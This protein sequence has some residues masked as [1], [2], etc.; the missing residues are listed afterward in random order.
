MLGYII[1]FYKYATFPH[2]LKGDMADYLNQNIKQ[3]K[4]EE[5]TANSLLV[6]GDFDR[7]NIKRVTDFT[8]Y[9]DVDFYARRWLGQR[10]SILLYQLEEKRESDLLE[11]IFGLGERKG[12][13]KYRNFVVLTMVTL[14][15]M[16]HK[17]ENY[18]KMLEQCKALIAKQLG[19]IRD[20]SLTEPEELEYQIYGSFSSSELVIIWSVNQ[21]S[22]AL[23]LTDMLRNVKFTYGK[24]GG[25][26]LLPFISFYSIVAQTRC[27]EGALD[28]PI[29]G[30]AEL[31][32]TFQDGVLNES[33]RNRFLEDLKEKLSTVSGINIDQIKTN[34]NAGEYDYSIAL[35]ADCLCDP[36]KKVFYRGGLLHWDNSLIKEYISLTHVQ[37]YYNMNCEKDA[38]FSGESLYCDMLKESG[39]FMAENKNI[40]ENIQLI[41]KMIYGPDSDTT[42]LWNDKESALENYR[43]F[44]LRCMI[45]HYFP[46]TDGLCDTID[47]LYSDYINNCSNL[48]SSAWASDLTT[49]F[50]EMVDYIAD[51]I[52]RTFTS[53]SLGRI[54]SSV[55]FDDIKKISSIFIQMIYH[56]AQSRRTVFI[57]PSCHLRYMGQYDMILHA[58]YGIEKFFINLAYRLETNDLQPFLVPTFM[59]DV[60]PE[61]STDM[62]K[63][64]HHYNTEKK[65]SGIFSINMPLG[66]MTDFLR[67]SMVMCHETAHFI[68][69]YDR[70]KRNQVMGMLIFSEFVTKCAMRQI[71]LA[72]DESM[73]DD[74]HIALSYVYDRLLRNMMP[75]VYNNMRDFYVECVHKTVMS[76]ENLSDEHFP[77]WLDYRKAVTEQIGR[78]LRSQ[79][80]KKISDFLYENKSDFEQTANDSLEELASSWDGLGKNIFSKGFIDKVLG[81]LDAAIG[82]SD[83]S[84]RKE[85][86]MK[87]MVRLF[88][89]DE[90]IC[91]V[92]YVLCD[93]YR[94]ACQDLFM[95]RVFHIN[96]VD[97]LVLCNRHKNDTLKLTEHGSV[98][99]R[100]RI[101]MVCDYLLVADYKE[102]HA[103]IVPTYAVL[104]EFK[105]L[106]D[107]YR[108]L[109]QNIPEMRLS[110]NTSEESA[111]L[112]D[113]IKDTFQ[114]AYDVYRDYLEDY[115][116]F[117]G[118]FLKQM[119]DSDLIFRFYPE[120][121]PTDCLGEFYTAW[122]KAVMCED[123]EEMNAGVFS[124]NVAMIQHFLY[125]D[126]IKGLAD[127][128]E[129]GV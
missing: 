112:R 91:S 108:V 55:M 61:V 81:L 53:E 1:N 114:N 101:A 17:C 75:I 85:S 74:E 95:I 122:K 32:L 44:G 21:Y 96:L 105:K 126:T 111:K 104:D 90:L 67:Y 69:P 22:D 11:Q 48:T 38:A 65:I 127:R 24:N 5:E 88:D 41:G 36:Y 118:L 35:P 110:K 117:R 89:T 25:S 52:I 86:L 92:S 59:I 6:Y 60:I 94:E 4:K 19:R 80:I 27:G 9:R 66:A 107:D 2:V 72:Y 87:D 20:L 120:Q 97:Y 73:N 78:L 49:Q 33:E 100:I 109:F 18:G 125:Q 103:N 13:L 30:S 64:Y 12:I 40:I 71:L 34:R 99:G 8:R 121:V 58:Y 62:Y 3:M 63:I 79:E 54:D 56:I 50:I 29:V 115:G 51:Q 26:C 37:L 82:I 116:L 16:L 15:P 77:K 93:A 10:Q 106:Y 57:V 47:L 83:S 84:L 7:L 46:E 23:R 119:E 14:D 76:Y 98:P 42:E 129:R 102:K 128:S 113:M 43:K 70:N 68:T 45:K 123:I 124:N 31:K 28:Q 39:D